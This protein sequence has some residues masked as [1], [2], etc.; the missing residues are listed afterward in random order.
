MLLL[1]VLGV[2]SFVLALNFMDTITLENLV[3]FALGMAVVYMMFRS[4][5]IFILLFFVLLALPAGAQDVAVTNWPS[6]VNPLPVQTS[7]NV[8]PACAAGFGF[9]LTCCG[10][11][12]VLR[13]ARRTAND[14]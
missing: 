7:V 1:C 6:F 9:G 11:G 5:G 4:M 13:M 3:A 14:C 12:W 10:F 8:W 2:L